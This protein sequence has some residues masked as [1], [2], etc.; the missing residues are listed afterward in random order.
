[1]LNIN[2]I[3]IKYDMILSKYVESVMAHKD[4]IYSVY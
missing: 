3:Y 4:K 2:F 1:M